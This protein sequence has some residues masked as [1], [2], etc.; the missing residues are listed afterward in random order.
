MIAE[1]VVIQEVCLVSAGAR[2]EDIDHEAG[3]ALGVGEGEPVRVEQACEAWEKQVVLLPSN[4]PCAM[5]LPMPGP[6]IPVMV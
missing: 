4:M 6:E 2:G 5:R 1:A 3:V